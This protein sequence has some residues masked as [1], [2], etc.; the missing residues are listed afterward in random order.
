MPIRKEKIHYLMINGV[1][2]MKIFFLKVEL[3]NKPRWSNM[4]K[5]HASFLTS[6]AVL[7]MCA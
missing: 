5:F 2:A 7:P 3:I 6:V 4:L 1:S